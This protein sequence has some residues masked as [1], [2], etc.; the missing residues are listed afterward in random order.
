MFECDI[1]HPVEGQIIKCEV[2]NITRAGIRAEYKSKSEN[3]KCDDLDAPF[4]DKDKINTVN[5]SACE[6]ME[7]ILKQ[8]EKYIDPNIAYEISHKIIVPLITTFK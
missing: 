5:A 1:C 3:E 2:K 8:V 6:F 4:L 7:L